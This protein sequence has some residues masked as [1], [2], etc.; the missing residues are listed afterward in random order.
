M[1]LDPFS[2]RPSSSSRCGCSAR[3]HEDEWF[4]KAYGHF[5]FERGWSISSEFDAGGS[6]EGLRSRSS[7][8]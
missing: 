8:T 3:R 1:K 2:Y 7:G 6:G 4:R 5:D